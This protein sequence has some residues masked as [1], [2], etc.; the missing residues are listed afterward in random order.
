MNSNKFRN[1]ELTKIHSR[2]L[3]DAFWHST[4]GPEFQLWPAL[5]LSCYLIK[6]YLQKQMN[7]SS[8]Q[9]SIQFSKKNVNIKILK[10]LENSI[11]YWK[12]EKPWKGI[13]LALFCSL[14]NKKNK[15]QPF[16]EK[17]KALIGQTMSYLGKTLQNNFSL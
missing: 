2:T 11:S 6:S 8:G 7:I 12:T 16:P 9:F 4:N 13:C 5:S 15:D 17:T 1:A 3:T 14:I 10:E